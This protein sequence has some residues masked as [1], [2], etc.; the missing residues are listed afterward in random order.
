M[1]HSGT[2]RPAE[3]QIVD[4]VCSG[5][6]D[7]EVVVVLP[8]LLLRTKATNCSTLRRQACCSCIERAPAEPMESLVA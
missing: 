3:R 5:D 7:D 8:A 4:R 1:H 2:A 6:D